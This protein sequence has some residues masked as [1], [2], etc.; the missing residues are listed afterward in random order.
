MFHGHYYGNQIKN[1]TGGIC[2][3]CSHWCTPEDR[4]ENQKRVNQQLDFSKKLRKIG[5]CMHCQRQPK[6]F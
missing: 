3:T 4:G 1:I 2:F 6:G 5:G